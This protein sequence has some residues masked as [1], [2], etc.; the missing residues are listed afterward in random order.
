MVKTFFQ[1]IAEIKPMRVPTE[2]NDG[3]PVLSAVYI[4]AS[5]NDEESLEYILPLR[6]A[7]N[8][9]RK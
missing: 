2:T 8:F 9:S 4:Q 7:M 3:S 1:N 5:K 6:T